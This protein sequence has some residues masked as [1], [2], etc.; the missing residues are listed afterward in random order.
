MGAGTASRSKR[1]T[2]ASLRARGR[3]DGPTASTLLHGHLAEEAA[4]RLLGQRGYRIIERNYRCRFGELDIVADDAGVLVFCEVRSRASQRFGSAL[5]AFPVAKR[6]QVAR[7]AAQYLLHRRCGSRRCRFD[8]VA[9]TG[10]H[11]V[12]VQ[13]AFRL[14]MW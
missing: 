1:S 2:A 7:V 3:P 12:L 14:E 13:D 6:R 11:V 4:A 8:I 5:E 10:E 9:V